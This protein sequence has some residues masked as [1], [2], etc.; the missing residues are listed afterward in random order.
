MSARELFLRPAVLVFWLV[1]AYLAYQVIGQLQMLLIC[2]VAALT[3]AA[4]LSPLAE[5]LE[6]R[7]IPRVVTVLAV[8]T[9]VGGLYVAVGMGLAPVI[10]N[11][12]ESLVKKVV[13]PF[14]HFYEEFIKIDDGEPPQP[15]ESQ[16]RT[17]SLFQS[18]A[19][20]VKSNVSVEQISDVAK[21]VAMQAVKMTGNFVTFLVNALFVLF[22]TAY[23]VIEAKELN[24]SLLSWLPAQKRERVA[25]LIRP[26]ENR[27]GGYVRGQILV[28]LAVGTI[29]GLGLSVIG[30]H[31][32]LILGVMAGFMN[33]V[34]FVGSIATAVFAVLIA[35]QTSTT[36]G[37]L[38]I[39]VFVLEQWVES[40][41]IV[42]HLLGK[43]V[44]LHPLV[45]LFSVI[46]GGTLLGLP[47]ALISVPVA[48]A[49]LFLAEELYKKQLAEP[50]MNTQTVPGTPS[51]SAEA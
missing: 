51:N 19:R 45:V 36:L 9:M 8:Y 35:F 14:T 39:L 46:I 32:A 30:I 11:Q 34:P 48:T 15:E 12:Y 50:S 41:F 6:A 28:S 3:L 47:G 17:D 38:A 20:Q 27:L 37:L 16:S 49:S 43:Q 21:Q 44:D 25:S 26:L 5:K 18:A 7:K 40:N 22:L 42:P 4:A 13:P 29:I 31:E 23:F 33:L 1:F 10:K 2:L 24:E